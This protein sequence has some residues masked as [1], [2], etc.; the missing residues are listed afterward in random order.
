VSDGW[1]DV[2]V[3]SAEYDCSL[4]GAYQFWPD[5]QGEQGALGSVFWNNYQGGYWDTSVL[6]H[7]GAWFGFAAP[8]QYS[9]ADLY[10]GVMESCE[11][12][13]TP[14]FGALAWED[15]G[16][17]ATLVS[18]E[19][20]LQLDWDSAQGQ[21]RG[22]GESGDIVAGAVY[23]LEPIAGAEP[24]WP[25]FGVASFARMP[26]SFSITNPSVNGA[27]LDFIVD[28]TL[29]LEWD[30]SQP[31]D[32]VV[33]EVRRVVSGVTAETIRCLVEDDGAFSVAPGNFDGWDWWE[34]YLVF[35]VGRVRESASVLPHN[36][37]RSGVV[38]VYWT[39]GA[40][41]TFLG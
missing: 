32:Y 7:G 19:G 6:P 28:D 30:A 9:Y 3:S 39:S 11:S 26:S 4:E 18:S 13:F 16:G 29:A 38:G 5:G 27:E 34:Q 24:D 1:A 31:A 2:Q 23:Q 22:D 20:T 25:D 12:G 10:G 36:R 41:W 15:V 8:T 35:D 14:S 37:S 17:Q 33:I 40:V 21:W